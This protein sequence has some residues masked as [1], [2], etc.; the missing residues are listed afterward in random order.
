MLICGPCREF[1]K[2]C[3]TDMGDRATS[4][5]ALPGTGTTNRAA[6]RPSNS[7]AS[8]L[9][10][11]SDDKQKRWQSCKQVR[12]TPV[13]DGEI[14]F[15]EK[16][17]EAI[18]FLGCSNRFYYDCLKSNKVC[19]GYL[20]QHQSVAP[21]STRTSAATTTIAT[22]AATIEVTRPTS[23]AAAAAVAA[24]TMIDEPLAEEF[25]VDRII[26]HRIA[27]NGDVEYLVSSKEKERRRSF[28]CSNS[29]CLVVW[30]QSFSGC[31]VRP[32]LFSSSP[33]RCA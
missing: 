28:L 32:L 23:R 31:C 27:L 6:I 29:I 20:L 14:R 7:P 1:N 15:F 13:G 5:T 9:Q 3:S 17:K 4:N 11:G 25:V 12:L 16:V 19:N 10:P 30:L 26:R 33:P 2:K 21:A 22:A 18:T 24:A 8:V